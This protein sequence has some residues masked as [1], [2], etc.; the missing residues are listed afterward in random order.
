[1]LSPSVVPDSA[2]SGTV[3]QVPMSGDFSGKDT[4]VGCHSLLQGTFP[5]QGSTREAPKSH[6]ICHLR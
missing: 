6:P 5:T 4:G 2:A 3:A 1:M